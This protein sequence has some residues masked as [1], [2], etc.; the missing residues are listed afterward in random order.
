MAG[1]DATVARLR[2]GPRDGEVVTVARDV[3]LLRAVSPAPGLLDLYRLVP[4]ASEPA[5]PGVERHG[6]EIL[7]FG[8]DGSEPIGETAPE[9]LHMPGSG[10]VPGSAG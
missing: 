3:E 10:S 9:L 4:G 1:V 6:E 2:G 7:V 5:P 8:Y